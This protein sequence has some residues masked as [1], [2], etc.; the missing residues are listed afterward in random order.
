MGGLPTETING[1]AVD[2][3]GVRPHADW[4]KDK[5]GRRKGSVIY[6]ESTFGPCHCYTG[7]HGSSRYHARR[8]R[9][10]LVC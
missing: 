10:G 1:F 8:A 4:T 7:E 2:P 5:D 3:R 6:P 9:G